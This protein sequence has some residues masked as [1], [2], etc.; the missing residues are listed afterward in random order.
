MKITKS[1]DIRSNL[2]IARCNWEPFID[3]NLIM[4]G[5]GPYLIA[6]ERLDDIYELDIMFYHWPYT[7][8]I[9][10]MPNDKAS[11]II[12][13]IDLLHRKRNYPNVLFLIKIHRNLDFQLFNISDLLQCKIG[14]YYQ[15]KSVLEIERNLS[16]FN[17][18]SHTSTYK[19]PYEFAMIKGHSCFTQNIISFHNQINVPIYDRGL[20]LDQSK[21]NLHENYVQDSPINI[22]SR[23]LKYK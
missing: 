11:S 20:I 14:V 23:S 4:D 9:F 17:T 22:P 10:E 2:L 7:Q 21:S 15:P 12:D 13:K 8:F 18:E 19:V 1:K 5:G 3:K 6:P 16:L